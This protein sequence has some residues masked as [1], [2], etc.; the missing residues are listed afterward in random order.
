MSWIGQLETT[1]DGKPYGGQI[2]RAS[3]EKRSHRSIF[4]EPNNG[5][6]IKCPKCAPNIMEVDEFAM[7]GPYRWGRAHCGGCQ[8][9]GFYYVP[10][11]RVDGGEEIVLFATEDEITAPA[12]GVDIGFS[13]EWIVRHFQ[14]KVLELKAQRDLKEM[15]KNAY[16][17]DPDHS[18]I[19]V[20]IAT[21][22][23]FDPITV[24]TCDVPHVSYGKCIS[25]GKLDRKYSHTP[26]EWVEKNRIKE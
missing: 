3:T 16:F 11:V 7:I 25:C 20:D 22:V 12:G 13:H 14:G 19:S 15:A 9:K 6:Q 24:C 8:T 26:E 2:T 21:G 17:G 23:K 4:S 10:F 1:K 18:P 5:F